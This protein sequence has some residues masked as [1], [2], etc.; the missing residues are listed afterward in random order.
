MGVPTT[1]ILE[2]VSVM[3]FINNKYTTLYF[4]IITSAQQRKSITGYAEN[5][6]IIPKSLGGSNDKS[7]LVTLTA[8]EHFICHL[9][10]V[11]MTVSK[12]KVK[13]VFAAWMMAS[14][15]NSNSLQRYKPTARLY[16]K[17]KEDYINAAI[18]REVSVETRKK[19]SD[20]QKKLTGDKHQRF[21]KTASDETRKKQSESAKKKPPV[22]E[23]T[24]Q[25]LSDA[26]KT[27]APISEET[28]QKMIVAL[29][30][31]APIS[32]ETRQ[33]M[34]ASH[35][36][37]FSGNKHPRFGKTVSEETR[38]KMSASAKNFIPVICP[39]CGLSGNRGNMARWHG[40]NCKMNPKLR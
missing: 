17:L 4:K 2:G 8:R 5:H 11:K 35:K 14:T 34:I 40:D 39:Y 37:Q 19:L 3:V 15:S 12:E 33:K 7:N 10:L 22:S 30:N 6:H 27:R 31:R 23:K 1:L 20:A 28:R 25:K 13:M 29:R 26:S 16:Q 24:R 18:T 36:G 9:L 21:G 38:N 32:E